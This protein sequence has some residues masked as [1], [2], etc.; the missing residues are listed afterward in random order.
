MH[1]QIFEESRP[2]VTRD[3]VE[4]VVRENDPVLTP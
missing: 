3:V 4:R 1:T 2:D